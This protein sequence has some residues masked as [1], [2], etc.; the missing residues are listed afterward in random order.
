M[1][2]PEAPSWVKEENIT[3][4]Q[5][6]ADVEVVVKSINMNLL[7]VSWENMTFIQDIKH[8]LSTSVI[9]VS[10]MLEEM[11]II[12]HMSFLKNEKTKISYRGV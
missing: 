2:I 10:L 1:V 11:E 3:E 8:L 5:L 12:L 6:V 7:L 9:L 4:I